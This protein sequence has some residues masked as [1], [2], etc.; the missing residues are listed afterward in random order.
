MGIQSQYANARLT[1]NVVYGN[2]LDGIWVQGGTGTQLVNNTVYQPTGNAVRIDGSG[3]ASNVE[4]RN[5]VLWTQSGYDVTV[6]TN[7]QIGFQSDY[8]LFFASGNG[9]V[10]QWQGGDRATLFAWQSAVFTDG[11]SVA[12]IRCSSIW[13]GPMDNLAT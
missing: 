11:N 10:G 5:N 9:Q 13:M 2:M 7:S 3:G 8:N 4:L 6:A 1:N 12:R